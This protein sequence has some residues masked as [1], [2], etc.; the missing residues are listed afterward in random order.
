VRRISIPS[1]SGRQRGFTLIELMVSLVIGFAV[2]G[3]LL[4]AY[5]ASFRSSAHND[6]MVQ[7]TED[8]TLAL[9]VIREQVAMAGYSTM[10]EVDPAAQVMKGHAKITDRF[11]FGCAGV[12][13]AD[14]HG[15]A[16]AVCGT[17]NSNNSDTIEVVYE[18]TTATGGGSNAILNAAGKPLDCIGNELDVVAA[19][20]T[21]AEY[22][23]NDVK[24]YVKFDANQNG[25]LYCEGPKGS[26]APL[27]DNVDKLTIRYGLDLTTDSTQLKRQITN[28]ATAPAGLTNANWKRVV[29]VSICVVVRSASRVN[30][31][32]SATNLNALDTYVDCDGNTAHSNDGYLR[33]SFATTVQLQN[34]FI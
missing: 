12:D 5:M 27:V 29:S 18:A 13:F 6:A 32:S 20:G 11:M 10:V 31:R 4:A 19:S 2:V 28:Y 21:E 25:R 9:N 24:F 7:V 30:D 1:S 15:I 16:S 14:F 33:R 23:P 3:A 17:T 26:G 8:A 22:Y 34:M